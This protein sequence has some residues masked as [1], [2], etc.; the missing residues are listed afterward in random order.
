M[1]KIREREV[2]S[3][4]TLL[5]AD[6]D[7]IS[8][9][10]LSSFFEE[11]FNILRAYSGKETLKTLSQHLDIIDL[12]LLDIYM[13]DG[14]G[15]TILKARQEDKEIKKIPFIVITG[16]A[17]IERDCFYLGVNDFV[18]KPFSNPEII[19]ARVKRMIELYEDRSIIKEVKTDKLTNLYSIEFFKKFCVQFDEVKP[20]ISKDMVSINITRFRLLNELYGKNY[21]DEVLKNIAKFLEHFVDKVKGF[22]SH[23]SGGDFLMYCSHQDNYQEFVDGL[24]NH[25]E[26][27]TNA[28]SVHLH[29]GV[30]PNVD[31]AL[32]KDLAI[33]RAHNVANSISGDSTIYALYDSKVEEKIFF[34]EELID[35]FKNSLKNREFKVFYQPKYNIQGEKNHLSS[36][37]ALIR[38]IHPKHGMISP[39]VFI[40]LFEENGFIQLLD[41]YVFEEVARQQAE[42]EKK[43]GV[44]LPVSVNV[45][46]VDIH[47]PNLEKELLDAVDKA[48]VPHDK[49]YL[50]ITESAYSQDKQEVINLVKSLKEKGFLIEID[51]FGSGY[52]SLNVVSELPFDVLKI[53]MVFIKKIDEHPMNKD[54]VKMIL[55]LCKKMGATSVAEGV[56]TEEHYKFLKESGCDVIQGYYFSKPLPENE[57]IKLM[58]KEYQNGR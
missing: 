30:Y 35:S 54:I 8:G 53:D 7:V 38:W 33:G 46:R 31:P 3:K 42:W 19:V 36:A 21:S 52:S 45:S 44:F 34:E 9:D 24:I 39:G 57:F 10:I 17:D 37:E 55:A 27:L 47:N 14:D 20:D 5:I 13:P 4:R 40:P 16:E 6:D 43:F 12:V 50:E 23:T 48:H 18:R 1:D 49:Y 29:I 32:D 26:Q 11:E 25:L 28:S 22:A 15:F 56:E 58:E 51:D 41:A 2:Q